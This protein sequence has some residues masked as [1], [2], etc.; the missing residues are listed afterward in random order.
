MKD[1]FERFQERM[2][3]EEKARLWQRIR[4]VASSDERTP[5]LRRLFHPAT[6]SAL[7][8]TAALTLVLPRIFDADERK[9]GFG[10]HA[11]PHEVKVRSKD[12]SERG[13]TIELQPDA[14]KKEDA[15]R[16]ADAKRLAGKLGAAPAIAPAP[17]ASPADLEPKPEGTLEAHDARTGASLQ[18]I[19][20]KK[21]SAAPGGREGP[22][23]VT[24]PVSASGAAADGAGDTWGVIV[25]PP[26][27]ARSPEVQK[28]PGAAAG[29]VSRGSGLH[30]R[31]GQTGDARMELDAQQVEQL[32][33]LPYIGGESRSTTAPNVPSPRINAKRDLDGSDA[34]ARQTQGLANSHGEPYRD[35][36]FRDHG[37]NPFLSTEEDSLSTFAVDVD[38]AAYTHVRKYIGEGHLP[39]KEAVRVEEFVNFFR[40][41]Y[42]VFEDEDFRILI[43]SAPSPFGDGYELVRVGIKARTIPE[44]ERR[45]ANL[46]FVIDVS[47]SM[48]ENGRLEL[49]KEALHLLVRELRAEDQVGIV[50]FSN[51]ARVVLEPTS[52][53]RR[54]DIAAAIQELQPLQSTNAE[55]GIVMGYRMADQCWRKGA[56]NRII[57]LSDGVANV[58]QTSAD[59]ILGEARTGA[60][61]SIYM[62]TIGVGMNNYNDV[63]LERMADAGDGNHYYVDNLDEAYRVFVQNLTGTIQTVA[64]DAKIQIAFDPRSVDRYRLLGFENRDVRDRDFRNDAVDAGEIGSG[65]E[66]TALYE[67]KLRSGS[68]S[69]R[70]LEARLRY[71]EPEGEEPEVHEIS[72]RFVSRDRGRKFEDAQV[73]LRLDAAVAEFAEVLRESYWARESRLEDVLP[74]AQQVARELPRDPD[75]VEFARLVEE[76]TRIS[77]GRDPALDV[78][79]RR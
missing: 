61:R 34:L 39:P 54:A 20:D 15:D 66:V 59:A 73:R 13:F 50:A 76:A 19:D 67:V 62:T 26:P 9:S 14:G 35:T 49:V 1:S 7:A 24:S 17:L 36:F 58:G 47:G 12:T 3:A 79:R 43:D 10:F 57:L 22:T 53:E 46:V 74:I 25:T 69:G 31:G 21:P 32:K 60:R 64:R 55:A 23:S 5:W 63:L 65:H 45:P 38:N 8:A 68:D 27:A 11:T 70:L 6:V 41:D 2:T 52:I 51:D 71:A 4:P 37:V 72:R 44:R 48:R 28:L 75:V 18:S 56:S 78:D 42:P 30:V 29:V 40:Q 16:D 33:N 77:R